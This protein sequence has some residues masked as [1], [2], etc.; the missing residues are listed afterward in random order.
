MSWL[1]FVKVPFEALWKR[2]SQVLSLAFSLR[3][4]EVQQNSKEE[5][6]V[7]EWKNI[8]AD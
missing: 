4:T 2:L 1:G 8:L 6:K 3:W 7:Q 5:T